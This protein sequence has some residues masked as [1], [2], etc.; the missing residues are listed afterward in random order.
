MNFERNQWKIIAHIECFLNRKR[1]Y[2]RNC[3][4]KSDKERLMYYQ[5]GPQ[6]NLHSAYRHI[7]HCKLNILMQFAHNI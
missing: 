2:N 1:L 4:N 3:K 6:V 7:T 5:G